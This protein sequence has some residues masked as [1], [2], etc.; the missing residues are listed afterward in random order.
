MSVRNPRCIRIFN[1]R[2]SV[3]N[4]VMVLKQGGFEAYS[5]EDKFGNLTLKMLHMR[6]RYRLY[7]QMEDIDKISEFLADKVIEGEVV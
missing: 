7:V 3:S 2:R 4:A 1:D 6:P 5:T